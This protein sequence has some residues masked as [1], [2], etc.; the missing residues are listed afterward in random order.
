ML[1]YISAIISTIHNKS[2][3]VMSCIQLVFDESHKELLNQSVDL[4]YDHVEKSKSL[5]NEKG[6]I[7]SSSSRRRI[8]I[9]LHSYS[10]K[11]TAA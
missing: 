11:A 1:E 3:V 6:N 10:Y 7:V 4:T 2:S 9:G 5:S 8:F